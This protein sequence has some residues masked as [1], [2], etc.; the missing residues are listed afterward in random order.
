MSESSIEE[1]RESGLT[2]R[3]LVIGIVLLIAFNTYGMIAGGMATTEVMTNIV[4]NVPVLFLMFILL[5]ISSSFLRKRGLNAS[6]LL[7]IFTIL[8]VSFNVNVFS[9]GVSSPLYAKLWSIHADT[10]RSLQP[11]F[12]FP[13][14]ATMTSMLMGG[15]AVP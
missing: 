15:A 9:W 8:S 6:E 10:V 12:W 13:D 14:V 1:V 7:V 4:T 3:A 11:S 2:L 5:I